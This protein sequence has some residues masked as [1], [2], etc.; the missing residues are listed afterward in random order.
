[1]AWLT[2]LGEE[3][4]C[5]EEVKAEPDW[6]TVGYWV[7]RV[8]PLVNRRGNEGEDGDERRGGEDG[9]KVVVFANRSGV[10][11]GNARYAGSSCV[12]GVGGE[13]N[14][15]GRVRVWGVMG[16]G[17][18]GLLVVDTVEEEGWRW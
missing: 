4:L 8:E 11:E 13:G 15:G 1:M 17:V 7:G 14:A 18:E 6:G 10:E 2:T 12:I 16:R 5:G 3:E 9:E